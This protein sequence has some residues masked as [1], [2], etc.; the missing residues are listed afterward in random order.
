ME[1]LSSL[2]SDFL[3]VPFKNRGLVF[4]S[5]NAVLLGA[6]AAMCSSPV[7]SGRG[8]TYT[9]LEGRPRRGS[10]GGRC[11][12]W[13][14]LRC[15]P[16]APEP[17]PREGQG[18]RRRRA[19]ILGVLPTWLPSRGSV[20]STVPFISVPP[21]PGCDSGPALSTAPLWFELRKRRKHKCFLAKV[22]CSK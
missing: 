3:I 14:P 21:E 16:T 18:R 11:G 10:A 6:E 4:K 1:S 9:A 8:W 12:S 17:S 19:G 15:P 2:F 5:K 13:G 22:L 7:Q 20:A